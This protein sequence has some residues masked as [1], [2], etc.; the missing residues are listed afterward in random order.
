[1]RVFLNFLAAFFSLDCRPSL[2]A[3]SRSARFGI[4]CGLEEDEAVFDEL[5]AIVTA[6]LGQDCTFIEA[7]DHFARGLAAVVAAVWPVHQEFPEA[8][9][10]LTD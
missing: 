8:T 5:I 4:H 10:N 1:M 9:E 7:G 2:E 6:A 3:A